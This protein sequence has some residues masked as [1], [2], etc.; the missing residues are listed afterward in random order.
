MRN[1]VPLVVA[2]V[3]TVATPLPSFATTCSCAGVPILGAMQTATPGNKKWIVASTYEFHDLS[4]LVSGSRTVADQTG[5]DRTSQALILEASR[6]L[7][8][9]WSISALLSA[10]EHQRDVGGVRDSVSG[11]GDAVLMLKFSPRTISLYSKNGL[12]FGLGSRLPIGEDSA[13][14]QG[15]TLAEDLQPSTGAYGAIAWV[16]AARALN[17]STSFRSYGSLTSTYNDENDRSFQFRPIRS[18]WSFH[19]Y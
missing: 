11:L 9:K 1:I 2:G 8:D 10:V 13:A 7:T 12:S 17:E 4:D 19:H 6:G 15:F 3:L 5:R 16:Y 14:T 18:K